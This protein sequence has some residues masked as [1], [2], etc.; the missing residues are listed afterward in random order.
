MDY[1]VGDNFQVKL[2]L[3]TVTSYDSKIDRPEIGCMEYTRSSQT[4][5]FK[6]S[7]IFLQHAIR[8]KRE[9]CI[10]MFNGILVFMPI[11]ETM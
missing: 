8:Y 10:N 5:S 9:L 2:K 3:A 6:D 7:E 1:S 4:I 11:R